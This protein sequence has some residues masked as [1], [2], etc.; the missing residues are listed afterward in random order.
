MLDTKKMPKKAAQE[1][2]TLLCKIYPENFRNFKFYS[3]QLTLSG[4]IELQCKVKQVWGGGRIEL[5]CEAELRTTVM[6]IMIRNKGANTSI[7]YKFTNGNFYTDVRVRPVS[8]MLVT[9]RGKVLHLSLSRV[10]L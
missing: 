3:L 2:D 8:V 4:W 10:F 1:K 7:C 6:V 5:Q 9:S